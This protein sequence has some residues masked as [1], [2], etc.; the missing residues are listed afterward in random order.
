M[1]LGAAVS[2]AHW[3]DEV[4]LSSHLKAIVLSAVRR[5]RECG[6]SSQA[7]VDVAADGE[8]MEDGGGCAD[9][10]RRVAAAAEW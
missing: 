4:G 8:T 6:R 5:E 1:S 3:E 9:R 7:V 10:R 2:R